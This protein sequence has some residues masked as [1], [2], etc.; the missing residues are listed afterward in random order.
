MVECNATGFFKEIYT[1]Y[2]C[3]QSPKTYRALLEHNAF[4]HRSNEYTCKICKYSFGMIFNL[5]D[6]MT[7]KHTFDEN[8][9]LNPDVGFDESI[10]GNIL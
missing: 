6:H 3:L 10:Y 9:E 4:V 8:E 1:Q 2:F 7:S 5:A